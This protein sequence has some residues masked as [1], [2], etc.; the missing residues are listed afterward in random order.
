MSLRPDSKQTVP[1]SDRHSFKGRLEQVIADR[2]GAET[3]SLLPLVER[4]AIAAEHDVTVL[5]TGATGTGKTYLARLIHDCSP[6]RHEPFVTV[7]CG[8]LATHL[9]ESELFG[10]VRGAFTGA[11][12][13]KDG[14]FAAAGQGTLFLD[15]ID[16]LGLDQQ[17][18][19]LRAVETGEYEPVGSNQTQHSQCRILAASNADLKELVE[20]GRFRR[21]LYYRLKVL[22][23]Y[24]PPLAERIEDIA[25]LARALTARFSARYRKAVWDLSPEALAVLEAYPWPGNLRELEHGVQ[26][27]VLLSQG[28]TL[29]LRHFPEEIR[30]HA[31]QAG[32]FKPGDR[33]MA[34]DQRERLERGL[35]QRA[36]AKHACNRSGAARELGVSRT[37]LYKKMRKYGVVRE[38]LGCA[39]SS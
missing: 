23:F 36:L 31:A 1:H 2:L 10:H 11:D 34:R 25:P 28:P 15:E 13:D 29:L 27:A 17:A 37:T 35:I 8:A 4:L 12:R 18:N 20:Q 38:Y 21:D 32:A 14:K 3:P 26:H 24:L 33:G 19:L 6:R 16:A 7:P 5:L 22:S 39:T 9:I 30:Q